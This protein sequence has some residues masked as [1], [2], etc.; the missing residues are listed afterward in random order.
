MPEEG[1]TLSGRDKPVEFLSTSQHQ[2]QGY[3]G[4]EE[5]T[6]L[7]HLRSQIQGTDGPGV[8]IDLDM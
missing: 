1:P 8:G 6:D 7:A 5:E 4:T 3:V 2:E